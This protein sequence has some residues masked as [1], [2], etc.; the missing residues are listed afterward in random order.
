ML[1]MKKIPRIAVLVLLFLLLV[2]LVSTGAEEARVDGGVIF[3]FVDVDISAVAKF[4]SDITGKNFIFD[5]RVKGKITIIA[6]SKLSVDDAYSLFTSVL[7]LKGFTLVP[8]GIDAYKIIPTADAKQEGVEVAVDR[9]PVNE[10]YIARLIP[11]EN[12]S[13][14]DALKFLQPVVSRSGHISSFG[15]GNLLLVMDSGLNIEKIMGIVHMI[16][17]P[18]LGE[19]PE[20]VFLKHAS[21]EDVAKILNEGLTRAEKTVRGQKSVADIRLN[22]IVLFGDRSTK[23]SMKRLIELLDVTSE[24]TQSTI[25]VY[26]LE[27]ANA[28]EMAKVLEGLLKPDAK[29]ARAQK[30]AVPFEAVTGISITPDKATNSL[31][32]VAS[33]SDYKNMVRVIKQLDKRRRQVFVEAMIVEAK[34]DKLRDLGIRWRAVAEKDDEPI[35][36]GGVGTFDRSSLLSIVSGLAGLSAGGLANFLTVPVTDTETGE[37]VDITVPGYAALFNLNEFRDVVDVLSTPQILTSDNAEAEI[38]VGENVPFVSSRER[39]ITTTNTVLSSIERTDVGITLR[40]TPHITEGDYVNI[41]LYQEISSVQATTEDIFINVGPTTS[42]RSTSTTVTVKDEQTVVIGGLMEE[43]K[44]ESLNKVPLLGDIPLMGLLFQSKR[45]TR[46][47]TNLLIFLTPYV[48]KDAETLADVTR[49]KQQEYARHEH[50]YVEGELLVR[51]T[52]GVSEEEALAVISG[53]GASVI[54]FI[55]EQGLYHLRLKQGQKVEKAMKEFLS[56]PEVELA[57]PNYRM[58]LQ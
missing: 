30:G 47:K 11:L 10:N 53:K 28:E 31:V 27:N 7:Q 40:I 34:I 18:P 14:E 25:N 54:S 1:P 45:V 2:P 3:N 43:K 4:V 35:F 19:E 22:A 38:L 48:I 51:F 56:A 12:I 57:E 8:S 50:Q 21:A 20:V 33:P 32:I 16:D 49:K 9:P 24:E 26:F 5:E 55:E 37:S 6:P 41:E 15:P 29:Q 36:V 52:K 58:R 23:D 13:S 17:Q 39:D 44:E 42:K 46:E